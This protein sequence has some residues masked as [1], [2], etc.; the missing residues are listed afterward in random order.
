MACRDKF[1]FTFTLPDDNYE[2]EAELIF[3]IDSNDINIVKQCVEGGDVYVMA[4]IRHHADK[5]EMRLSTF[6]KTS[7]ALY[8]VSGVSFEK[9]LSTLSI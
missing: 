7:M 3:Y 1:A 5:E 2:D 4:N 9:M 6:V 8:K